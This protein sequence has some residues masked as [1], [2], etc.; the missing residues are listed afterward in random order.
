MDATI[1][2]IHTGA[3][4][5]VV[6]VIIV[7]AAVFGF[8]WQKRRAGGGAGISGFPWIAVIL[9]GAL[10]GPTIVVPALLAILQ[11]LIV[12]AVS[13]FTWAAQLF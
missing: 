7:L 13:V 3:S 2:Q 6:G 4:V 11:V 10:A 8:L 9:G 12:L 5:A 1:K